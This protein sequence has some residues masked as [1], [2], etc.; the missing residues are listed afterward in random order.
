MGCGDMAAGW[1]CALI[2]AAVAAAV[3]VAASLIALGILDGWAAAL[4]MDLI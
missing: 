1:R 2:G 4:V 3:L